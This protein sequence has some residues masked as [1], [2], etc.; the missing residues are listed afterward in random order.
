MGW[1]AIFQAIAQSI[2]NFVSTMSYIKENKTQAKQ[3]AEQAQ[4]QADQRGKKAKYDMQ[5]QKTSFLKGGVYFNDGTPAEVIDETY[6]TAMEDINSINKDSINSQKKLIRA[7]KTALFTFLVDPIGNN[8]AQ[9]G[10]TIASSFGNKNSK[11]GQTTA[12]S[13]SNTKVSGGIK[14][15]TTTFA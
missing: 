12:K 3:L 14:G 2:T 7:G 9:Y 8:G 1:V 11:V 6:N 5:H 4:E 15:D 10:Q 13:S